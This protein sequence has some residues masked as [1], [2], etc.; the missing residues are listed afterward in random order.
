MGAQ[1]PVGRGT[2]QGEELAAGPPGK[3]APAAALDPGDH[4]ST[5]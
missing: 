4:L 1:L 5:T 2:G 3:A